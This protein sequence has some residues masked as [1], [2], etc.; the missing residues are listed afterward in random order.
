[1]ELSIHA[2]G[3][4]FIVENF[5]QLLFTWEWKNERGVESL[6]HLSLDSI[7]DGT[8][9]IFEHKDLGTASAH[10]Y[11]TGWKETFLKLERVLT[12]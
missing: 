12:I 7:N 5:R 3:K 11:L 6:V 1:M 9:M 10:N 2:M 4:Y 8:M